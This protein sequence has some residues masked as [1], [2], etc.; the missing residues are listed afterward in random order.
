M[1]EKF[2][3]L[4]VALSF[5]RRQ[6]KTSVLLDVTDTCKVWSSFDRDAKYEIVIILCLGTTAGDRN[7]CYCSIGHWPVYV[8]NRIR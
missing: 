1:N 3:K 6:R 5:M 4:R 8:I 2:M 7:I